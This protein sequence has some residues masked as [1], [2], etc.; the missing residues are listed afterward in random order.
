M[1][2]LRLVL[3]LSGVLLP[4]LTPAIPPLGFVWLDANSNVVAPFTATTSATYLY[5]TADGMWSIQDPL[6]TTPWLASATPGSVQT[7]YTTANCTGTAYFALVASDVLNF[8]RTVARDGQVYVAGTLANVNNS[9]QST[10]YGSCVAQAP[11][12]SS[13]LMFTVV[14]PLTPPT[15]SAGPWRVVER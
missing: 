1:K 3:L 12:P 13:Y 9:I 7:F 6:S 15:L 10:W 2:I 5:A 8:T 14:G 4:T 11:I